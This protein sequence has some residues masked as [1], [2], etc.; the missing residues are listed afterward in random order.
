AATGSE[1]KHEGLC[2]KG[3]GDEQEQRAKSL[4]QDGVAPECQHCVSSE[5]MRTRESNRAPASV[6]EVESP[7]ECQFSQRGMSEVT[8]KDGKGDA[9]MVFRQEEVWTPQQRVC[10]ASAGKSDAEQ[11]DAEE[12]SSELPAPDELLQQ[13]QAQEEPSQIS[14]KDIPHATLAQQDHEVPEVWQTP[15]L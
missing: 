11:R 13:Q 2:C 10:E 15:A 5:A 14:K 9:A 4:I 3:S 12:G 6:D 1:E 8:W 7:Q